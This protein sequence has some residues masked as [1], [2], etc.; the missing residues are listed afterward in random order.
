MHAA[1]KR[2]FALQEP[3]SPQD[4]DHR[5][6][7]VAREIHDNGITYN[8]YTDPRGTP[9]A[10]AL[11]LLPRIVEAKEWAAIER[12]VIQWAD[13]LNAIATDVYGEQRL[14]KDGLLP[15]ALVYGHAGYIRPL[16][17]VTPPG[18]NYL[19]I[20]A[21]DLAR[22]PDGAWRVVSQRTQGPSGLG[23]VLEN[24]MIVSRVFADAFR[25]LRVQRLA[26]TYR[27]LL[28]G[29]LAAARERSGGEP[30]RVALLTPGP[31]NETYFEHAY[32][33]RY[34]GLP[35]VEGGDLT[36]RSDRVFLKTV[37]GLVPVHVLLRRLDDDWCDP[38]EL[39]PDSTLGIPGL[40]QAVRAGN[41]V[42]ANAL[43]TGFME[44]PGLQGF[45]PAISKALTGKELALP[46]L[47]TWWC[48][49]EAAWQ[50]V[51]DK[52][53]ERVIKATYAVDLRRGFAPAIGNQL[54]EHEL[55]DWK[56]RISNDPDAF[57]IQD[58]LPFSQTPVWSD[59]YLTPRTAMLRV[60]V[61]SKAD[62]GWYVLP[63]GLTRT[64]SRG[65][66]HVVSLQRG[67]SSLDTWVMTDA[68]VDESTLVQTGISADELSARAWPV[69]SR[70]AENL[71][72]MGRY[73]ERTENL[74]RLAH[75]LLLRVNGQTALSPEVSNTL[76][77]LAVVSGLAPQGVPTLAQAPRVFERAVRMALTD[78]EQSVSISFNLRAL[79]N[80]AD[81]VRDRLS[82]EHARLVRAMREEFAI[83]RSGDQAVERS[84]V[85]TLA[86]LEHLGVQLAAITGAQSD[87]M[88]RDDGWRFLMIGRRTERLAAHAAILR[89]A[90]EQ[91]AVGVDDGFDLLLSLFDSAITYRAR[92]QRRRH[93]AALGDLVIVDEANPRSLAGV[94]RRLRVEVERLPGGAQAVETLQALLPATI[95]GEDIPA[96]L[97][98]S[99]VSPEAA[100]LHALAFVRDV[101]DRALRFSDEL[102]RRY[103]VHGD[104][105]D[106]VVT[107]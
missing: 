13:L 96:L 4:L 76:T 58:Y 57:T 9:R 83:T 42:L 33:A 77:E 99:G 1:W 107:A 27:L 34:L 49:E 55:D 21:F 44:S 82:L 8:V 38:L 59:G 54:N 23:Y 17:G 72:W 48:G 74:Q 87:R 7:A 26:S 41:V 14:L 65:N 30:P 78:E 47:S 67:G 73:A 100:Q 18:G 106:H 90:L 81:A 45:L 3:F 60:Y 98:L 97:G 92:F 2:F 15:P 84:G 63:G 19:H 70:A 88:T 24:R 5:A 20:V 37:K 6:A 31:Y 66:P 69:S 93:W 39:R 75:A 12:G 71:F 29:L 46:S 91:R 35:L 56:N 16:V 51:A 105:L 10:W 52:L 22:A 40:L 86:A 101:E 64:A 103:F 104:E 102:G 61:M 11:E 85:N 36:V 94:L 62:G 89:I 79:A 32:L 25:E 43:G 50:S 68:V 28:D 80:T 95:G 53:K